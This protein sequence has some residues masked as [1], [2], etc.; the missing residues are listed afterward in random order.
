MKRLF[1]ASLIVLLAS[2][3]SR[4]ASLYIQRGQE[5]SGS[6]AA[7]V[8]LEGLKEGENEKLYYNLA[9]SYIEEGM[10]EEAI[11]IA[12]KALLTSPQSLRFLNLK[13][14]CQREGSIDGYKETIISIIGYYPADI[15]A[16]ELLLGI[17]ISEGDL[18]NAEKEAM[19]IIRRDTDNEKAISFLASV[20]PFYKTIA[21]S[22]ELPALGDS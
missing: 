18:E 17:Y 11:D 22:E 15:E 9:Y 19:E 2:C 13:A 20:I 10:F 21:K 14:Y 7:E 6:K 1:L 16:R 4:N 3:Q 8:Y 5:L 12:D